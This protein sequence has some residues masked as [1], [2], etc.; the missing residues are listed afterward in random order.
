MDTE[1]L[2]QKLLDELYAGACAGL[3]AMLLEEEEI[4]QADEETLREIER[5]G[6]T[7]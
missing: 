4:R 7:L 3:P 6:S 5:R 1:E 2:R